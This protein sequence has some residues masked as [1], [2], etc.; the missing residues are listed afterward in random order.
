MKQN[1]VTWCMQSE[2]FAVFAN[3]CLCQGILYQ[4]P[5]YKLQVKY[6]N[7]LLLLDWYIRLPYMIYQGTLNIIK[8]LTEDKLPKAIDRGLSG[9]I[10]KA[11]TTI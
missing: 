3:L 7:F 11:T 4:A 2:S 10:S 8:L 1:L 9:S 6:G 5:S